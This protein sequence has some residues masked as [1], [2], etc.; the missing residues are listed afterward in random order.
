M[1]VRFHERRSTNP[2]FAV[3]LRN[4]VGHTVF[5]TSTQWRGRRD[6]QLRAR[7]TRAEVRIALETWFAPSH[8]KLT[9]SVARDGGGANALDLREDL[10]SLVVHSTQT[11]GGI[12]DV[13]HAIE[14]ERR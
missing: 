11:T 8:Y 12:V 2:I 9:P 10:A 14:V 1:R 5:S 13:P 3:S 6:R 7:A 4:E